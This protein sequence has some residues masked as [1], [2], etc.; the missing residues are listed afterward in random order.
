MNEKRLLLVLAAIQFTNILD[1]MIMMPLGPQLMRIFNVGP[2][3]FSALVSAYTFS[4]GIVGFAAAFFI[5]RFPRKRMLELVYLGFLL[6]TLAC[7]LSPGYGWLLASRIFTGAFGG[8]LGALVMSVVG[9]VIPLERRARA[10]GQIMAAFSAASV[11]G[12]PLGLYL[13]SVMSWHAPFFFLFVAC[14]FI[15]GGIRMFIPPISTAVQQGRAPLSPI[16]I[17]TTVIRQRNLRTALVLTLVMMLGNFTI[18]PFI[19]PTMVA[20]VGFSEKQLTYIYLAG[21]FIT[22]FSS[23]LIGKLADKHGPVRVFT[24]FILIAIVPILLITNMGP[25]PIPIAL[26]VTSSYFVISGGRMIPAQ[27]M[28]ASAVEPAFR[29]SFMSLN[30]SVQQLGTAVAAFIA[31]LIMVRNEDGTLSNYPYVGLL[32]IALSLVSIG[33][34]RRIKVIS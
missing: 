7:A 23:P 1:F 28:V 31:G 26:L 5:D 10:M 19:S 17:I 11:L 24:I 15:W 2:A 21:G 25:L 6:G 13:A 8:M 4:A 22:L 3:S 12:V 34:A 18:T 33:V 27:A 9:E 14:L 20:N 29:G 32:A 30:S 16:E